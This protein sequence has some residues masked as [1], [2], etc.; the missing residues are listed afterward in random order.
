M[1]RFSRVSTSAK[2]D[3]E[4]LLPDGRQH[5]CNEPGSHARMARRRWG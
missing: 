3:G 5:E 2:E 1:V 4:T